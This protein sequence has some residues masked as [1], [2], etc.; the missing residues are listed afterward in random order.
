MERLTLKPHPQSGLSAARQIEAGASLSAIGRLTVEFAV[1]GDIKSI[2]FPQQSAPA[3]RD[4]LWRKTCFEAFLRP[5]RARGYFEFNFSP[6]TEWAAYQF[7][8]YREDMAPLNIPAPSI[9]CKAAAR[10]F[11][12]KAIVDLASLP[13]AR[14]VTTWKLGLSAII[15]D[16]DGEKSYW[17][18][19]H[20]PGKPD[21]HHRDSFAHVL[22]REDLS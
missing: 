14:E 13:R 12:M 6:S 2:R 19:A 11:Q 16:A 18:L 22:D 9:S 4:G 3:R 20:S 10:K 5:P 1:S 21:F 7:R 17:S 15:E 8:A